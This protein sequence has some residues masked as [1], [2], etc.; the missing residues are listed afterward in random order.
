MKRLSDFKPLGLVELPDIGSVSGSGLTLIVGPNSAGKTRLLNDLNSRLCGDPRSTVVA[1]RIELNKPEYQPLI[2]CLVNE[3]YIRLP[4]DPAGRQQLV[5]TTPYLG[6]GEIQP[7]VGMEQVRG[8]YDA[9]P[10]WEGASAD[11]PNEFLQR[12]GRLLVTK[13]SLE[14]R[15]TGLGTV[16]VINFETA[17]PQ[18][19][20]HS[21]RVNDTA[22][23]ELATET[24]RTFGKAVWPDHARGDSLCLR[25]ADGDLPPADDRLSFVK[26]S[27]YRPI[28]D[29]GDGLKSY[30]SICIALLLGLRPVCLIDEPEMCL[31]PPQAYSLA[32]FI[33]RHAASKETATFVATHSAHILRGVLQ[34]THDL[35]IIRLSRTG[36]QFHAHRVSA[37]KLALALAKPTLRAET[38]LDGIFSEAI[39]IVEADG[40]RLVYHTTWET[41]AEEL[42]LDVHFAA[43]GGIGGVGCLPIIPHTPHP[44]RRNCRLRRTQGTSAIASHPGSDGWP[45]GGEAADGA[46][47]RSD[48]TGS[49]S[50]SDH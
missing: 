30:V 10:T 43:G 42:K 14:R 12:I 49:K 13:L 21:L 37:D 36:D 44:R 26:M 38:I 24:V 2:D 9:Y 15:L 20:L 4:L 11:R 32:R 39:V 41:L 34:S 18:T 16:G 35:E 47:A 33:G 17:P 6:T 23:S 40:D 22:C 45:G 19:E 27:R 46:D 5:A 1:R 8:W 31:H 3:G 29:E 50:A 7:P 48:G 25:V 28:E